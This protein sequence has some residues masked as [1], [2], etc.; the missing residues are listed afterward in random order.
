MPRTGESLVRIASKRKTKEEAMVAVDEMLEKVK[1]RIG[2]YIYNCDDVELS[3]MVTSKL[4]AHNISIS[5]AESCTGGLFAAALTEKPG[6]SAVFDR[7]IVTYSNRAKVE[8]LG[9]SEKTLARFGAV[10]HETAA[11]MA[12][13]LAEKTGSDIC[14]SVTG[15]AGPEGGTEEKP[16]GLIYIGISYKLK[17][18]YCTETIELLTQRPDRGRNRRRS[19][20]TMF[21]CVNKAIDKMIE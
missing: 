1:E 17:G 12:A 3:D 5:C 10:S 18:T 2:Q 11:E 6:I 9:V 20:L 14:V 13:G 7:G 19:V 21:D 16:V 15:I 4:L 8:E